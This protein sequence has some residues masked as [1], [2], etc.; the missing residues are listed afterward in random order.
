MCLLSSLCTYDRG[1]RDIMIEAVCKHCGCL[2]HIPTALTVQSWFSA[3]SSA[4][5][6]CEKK[7]S[8]LGPK[9]MLKFCRASWQ[10]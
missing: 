7:G 4:L 2:T 6:C 9:H 3:T 5:P 10:Y 1:C 8:V